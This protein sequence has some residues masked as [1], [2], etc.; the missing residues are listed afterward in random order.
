MVSFATLFAALFAYVAPAAGPCDLLAKATITGILGQPAAAGR[1]MGPEKDE[2]TDGMISFCTFQGGQS[3][4]IVSEVTFASPAAA[5]KATTQEYV[6]NK[7]DDDGAAVKQESGAGDR[8]YWAT[9]KEGAE[10]VVVK[11]AKVISVA[12]GGKLPKPPTSYHDALRAAALEAAGA[13]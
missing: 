2:D 1:P 12:F 5:M 3:A 6:K 11:G 10:Y 9:T 8:A 4:I 7:M 13:R